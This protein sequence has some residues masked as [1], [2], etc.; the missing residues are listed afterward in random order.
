M[1]CDNE[2]RMMHPQATPALQGN[3]HRRR[4]IAEK[5]CVRTTRILC[6]LPYRD[7]E[8]GWMKFYRFEGSENKCDF[9]AV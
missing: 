9:L 3:Q 5:N 1:F 8:S 2:K 7:A 4:M 6:M